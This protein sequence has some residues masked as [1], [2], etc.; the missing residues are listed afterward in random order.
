MAATPLAQRVVQRWF[1][2]ILTGDAAELAQVSVPHPRLHELTQ[3][4]LAPQSVA[5]RLAE[6]P[7]LQVSVRELPNDRTLA[8]WPPASRGAVSC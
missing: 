3:T 6:L 8:C 2:A 5:R 7:A 1:H 4:P